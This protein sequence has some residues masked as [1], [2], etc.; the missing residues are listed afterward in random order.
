MLQVTTA[1]VGCAHQSCGRRDVANEVRGRRAEILR[2]RTI[3]PRLGRLSVLVSSVVSRATAGSAASKR[4]LEVSLAGRNGREIF[5][6][7][8]RCREALTG[9]LHALLALAPRSGGVL[10]VTA[11]IND[12]S[13]SV[14]CRG[15]AREWMPELGRKHSRRFFDADWREHPRR[16]GLGEHGSAAV[17]D[18]R[19]D[20]RRPSRRQACANGCSSRSSCRGLRRSSRLSANSFQLRQAQQFRDSAESWQLRGSTTILP[21]L[22][23]RAARRAFQS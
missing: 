16:T 23:P 13:S 10:E 6:D 12:V 2:R 18:G 3:R 14:D 22:S 9:M 8:A 5:L 21:W 15:R 17:R 7:G 19:A 20:A 4:P 1:C 11:Q